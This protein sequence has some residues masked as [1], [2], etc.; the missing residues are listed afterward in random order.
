MRSHFKQSLMFLF[1]GGL[2][3]L[4]IAS[5]LPMWALTYENPV[6]GKIQWVSLWSLIWNT[7]IDPP[8]INPAFPVTTR[9][10]FK[11][12]IDG[13]FIFGGGALAGLFF[14]YLSYYLRSL[15]PRNPNRGP[16]L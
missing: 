13:V 12:A 10:D 16:L 1:L 5:L 14:Y 15:L 11:D 6:E 2:I 4:L 8:Q 3:S 9:G 7:L